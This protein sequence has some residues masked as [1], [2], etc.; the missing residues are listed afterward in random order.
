MVPE[1]KKNKR[2]N[3]G[4]KKTVFPIFLVLFIL[5]IAIFLIIVNIRI[6]QK[7]AQLSGKVESLK[8]EI[9]TSEERNKE[10]TGEVSK[11][12]QQEFIEKEAR[13]RLNLKKPE[14]KVIVVLPSEENKQ[15]IEVKKSFFQTL[16]DKIRQWAENPD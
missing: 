13:E 6:G 4:F 2:R 9:Q 8:K 16:F 7:R 3:F 1:T 10:L 11:S 15:E 5:G 12:S 14:E